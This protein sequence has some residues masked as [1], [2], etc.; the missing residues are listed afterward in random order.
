M[1]LDDVV[2]EVLRVLVPEAIPPVGELS[3]DDVQL[4]V[5][6]ARLK[7]VIESLEGLSEEP[8]AFILIALAQA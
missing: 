8:L 5:I 3:G 7:V 6:D 2:A 4:G 1:L